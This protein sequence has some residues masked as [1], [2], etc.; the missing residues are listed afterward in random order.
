[1]FLTGNSPDEESKTAKQRL[2]DGEVCFIFVVDI[3]NGG[4]DIPEVNTVLFLRPTESLT[5]APQRR[6]PPTGQ[7]YIHHAERR[8]KVL[9]LLV[10]LRQAA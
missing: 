10:D 4:V 5:R 1:M 2:V 7:R 6:I 3:Y 8:S 9:L